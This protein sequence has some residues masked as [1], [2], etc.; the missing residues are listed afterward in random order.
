MPKLTPSQY[1][2]VVQLM[3]EVLVSFEQDIQDAKG[4][5]FEDLIPMYQ[6][7]RS[8]GMRCLEIFKDC[9]DLY[10]LTENLRDQDT[11]PRELYY[12]VFEYFDAVK[13]KGEVF[14]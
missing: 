14:I 12:K 6:D 9:R 1:N 11:A 13:D 2:D 5:E 3:E 7:D 10:R 8:Y 4:T